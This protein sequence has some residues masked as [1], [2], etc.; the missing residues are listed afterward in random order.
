[1]CLIADLLILFLLHK[2]AN[3]QL[4]FWW[5]ENQ[6]QSLLVGQCSESTGQTNW[7]E[8][9]WQILS[10]R[11]CCCRRERGLQWLLQDLWLTTQESKTDRKGQLW[12]YRE[13]KCR[14]L[15]PPLCHLIAEYFGQVSFS[16]L[17]SLQLCYEWAQN[18]SSQ[19]QG[20]KDWYGGAAWQSG[21]HR[22]VW[23]SY[24]PREELSS[25]TSKKVTS[26]VRVVTCLCRSCGSGGGGNSAV[27]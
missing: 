16:H 25:I 14:S 13:S 24:F 23:Y 17:L 2:E 3:N 11:S 27:C 6:D 22:S 9:R 21:A 12:R 10:P 18:F 26:L 15:R 20:L 5:A 1:M 7:P 8:G 4:R 19:C